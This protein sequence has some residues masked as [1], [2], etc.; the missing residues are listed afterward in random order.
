MDAG[1]DDAADGGDG[2]GGPPCG[3]GHGSGGGGRHG[4][5]GSPTLRRHRSACAA[6]AA[7]GGTRRAWCVVEEACCYPLLPC[8]CPLGT[9]AD[10]ERGTGCVAVVQNCE[11]SWSACRL[12]RAGWPS[13]AA[14]R[15]V[16]TAGSFRGCF[17]DVYCTR[18]VSPA[19]AQLHQR[20]SPSHLHPVTRFPA[21]TRGTTSY[22]WLRR[23]PCARGHMML[24]FYGQGMRWR[25][26]TGLTSKRSNTPKL[27]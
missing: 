23:C 7:S 18:S 26:V 3:A 21:Q 13:T 2:A 12:W 5:G 4:G 11:C 27:L 6:A 22:L 15:L 1:G 20:P 24:G 9:N 10:S 25:S 19:H 8:C 16:T 14:Q 17:G